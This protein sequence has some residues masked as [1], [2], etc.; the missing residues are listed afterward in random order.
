M[1]K[2][3]SIFQTLIAASLMFSVAACNTMNEG[4]ESAMVKEVSTFFYD[5][6][7]LAQNFDQEVLNLYADDAQLSGIQKRQDGT[8]VSQGIS[9]AQYK[10]LYPVIVQ[11]AQALDDWS[12]FSNIQVGMLSEDRARITADR[13]SHY[14]CYTDTD[15][16]MVVEKRDGNW[17]IVEEY[18]VTQEMMACEGKENTD[19]LA[20]ALTALA[21]ATNPHLPA[22]IDADTILEEM[23]VDGHSL[24]YYY[25]LSELTAEDISTEQFHNIMTPI[26]IEQSCT[27]QNLRPL[28][29]SGAELVYSYDGAEGAFI[30]EVFVVASDCP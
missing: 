30:G 22:Q 20:M 2:Y 8:E 21:D 15:Y 9:G 17:L 7:S 29:D 1:K 13:Y 11:Q 14:K 19:P 12:E 4:P 23:E 10:A 26:F 28:L 24:V 6:Q 25:R 3:F 5:Y 16:F 27:F 18:Q